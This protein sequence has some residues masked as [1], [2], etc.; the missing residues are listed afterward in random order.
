[1]KALNCVLFVALLIMVLGCESSGTSAALDATE[2][3]VQLRQIQSRVF[4]TTEQTE[5]LRSVMHTLQDLGFVLDRADQTMGTVSGT[6]LGVARSG[7][8]I[9]MTVSVRSR[10]ET[11]TLVRANAQYGLKAIE[12]PKPYQAFFTSL[13]KAMFLDAHEVTG[14]A[15]W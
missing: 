3:Q 6:Q 15:E 1:M 2:S 13:S 8:T 9:R 4:D 14:G 11:Q 12:D 7:K 10:G 5:V